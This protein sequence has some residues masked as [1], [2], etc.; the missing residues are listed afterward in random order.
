M[1]PEQAAE[2]GPRAAQ[3]KLFLHRMT[4]PDFISE[5]SFLTPFFC[6]SSIKGQELG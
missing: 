1:L 5:S 3:A 6:C 4:S 2:Q